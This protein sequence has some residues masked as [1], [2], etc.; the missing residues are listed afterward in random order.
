[1]ANEWYN[2]QCFRRCRL[3][4]TLIGTIILLEGLGAKSLGTLQP[5]F[6]DLKIGDHNIFLVFAI[7]CIC[8]L[9]IIFG[10]I[11]F[12]FIFYE[13]YYRNKITQYLDVLSVSNIS[14]FALDEKCHGYYI[15]GRSVHQTADTGIDEL[16][17][18]LRQEQ[19]DICP[20]RGIN[21]T[22]EQSFE[23]F[24][25]LEWRKQFDLI[26]T[27][28]SNAN[29]VQRTNGMMNRLKNDSGISYGMKP[30]NESNLRTYK[31]VKK[32]LIAFLDNVTKC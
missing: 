21:D 16:N 18:F 23:I 6:Q 25:S 28:S 32:F 2:L 9:S 19:C 11:L 27:A 5:Q 8:W 24:T 14:M 4:F 3:E 15:H 10:Q 13:R 31:A 30:A 7:D 26:Y 20:R 12:R 1:M 17:N 22:D 29:D